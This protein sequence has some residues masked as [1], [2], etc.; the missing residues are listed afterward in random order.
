MLAVRGEVSIFR[1]VIKD[2]LTG[3][4]VIEQNFQIQRR[5]HV[6]GGRGQKLLSEQV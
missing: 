3:Q 4:V 6:D 2:G 5:S 1:K